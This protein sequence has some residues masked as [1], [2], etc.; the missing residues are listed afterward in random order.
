MRMVG[1]IGLGRI[2]TPLVARLVA[3]GHSVVATDVRAERRPTVEQTG[4]HW[5]DS[6][7][8]NA[9]VVFTVLPGSPELREL[10]LG[11]GRL[12]ERLAEGTL[13]IDLTSASLELGQECARAAEE[14]AVGYLDAPIGGGV[15]AMERGEVT[16]YVGG[17]DALVDT[18]EPLLRSF[19]TTLHRTGASGTGYLTKLLINL[20]WFG[21]AV[22]S[23]E[24]LLLAQRHG[25]A[26]ERLRGM[27]PGSAG[28]SAFAR[29]HLSALLAGDYLADFGLDRCV[30]ELD[31]VERSADQA[32]LP[33]PVMTAVAALHRAALEHY[34]PVDGELLAAAWL[35]QQAGTRLSENS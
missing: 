31:A 15:P 20:L 18:A 28:D 19:A 11:S 13:W 10:V 16:L 25:L 12:L 26:P 17:P 23:T 9:E 14:H 32:N 8:V 21:Q 5:T 27:L 30:E 2:G 35:E 34:G 3:A 29:D 7:P 1:V 22:L 6:L 4:A 33:H 24:A